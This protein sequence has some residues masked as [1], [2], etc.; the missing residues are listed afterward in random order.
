MDRKA[1]HKILQIK[2]GLRTLAGMFIAK[3]NLNKEKKRYKFRAPQL[4]R[5][6]GR[7]SKDPTQ[8]SPTQGT[9]TPSKIWPSQNRLRN[10]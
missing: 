3:N 7:S 4:A 2:A 1:T 9:K 5:H 6:L 8:T 10:G